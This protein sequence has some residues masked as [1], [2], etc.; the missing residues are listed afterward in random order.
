MLR[1]TEVHE[2]LEASLN[3]EGSRETSGRGIQPNQHKRE[4]VRRLLLRFLDE[5]P[6]DMTVFEIREALDE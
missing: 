5:L 4:T 3:A 6:E 2:A 1:G